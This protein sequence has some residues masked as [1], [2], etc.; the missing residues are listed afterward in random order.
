MES[1]EFSRGGLHLMMWLVHSFHTLFGNL[2][3]SSLTYII[4]YYGLLWWLCV[5]SLF[6][7]P[8]S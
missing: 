8:I 7:V 3:L 2:L 1:D 5:A 4:L 6:V